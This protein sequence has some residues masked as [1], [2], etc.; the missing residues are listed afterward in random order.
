M[1][2]KYIHIG[3]TDDHVIEECAELTKVLIKA[4]RFGIDNYNPNDPSKTTNREKIKYE[5]ND[6]R[7]AI[8]LLEQEI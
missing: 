4:K 8:N 7:I 6:V 2:D 5:M 3:R 1:N